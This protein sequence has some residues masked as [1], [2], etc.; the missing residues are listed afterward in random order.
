MRSVIVF[1][2]VK[3]A[4]QGLFSANFSSFRPI[5]DIALLKLYDKAMMENSVLTLGMVLSRV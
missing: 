4:R 2:R 5:M 1:E 3:K